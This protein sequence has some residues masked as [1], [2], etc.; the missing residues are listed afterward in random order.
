MFTYKNGDCYRG[1]FKEGYKH[2]SGC[3]TLAKKPDQ[4]NQDAE[5][6]GEYAGDFKL[7]QMHGTG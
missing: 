4:E 2:G 1:Q 5:H 6:G 3:L 7:D